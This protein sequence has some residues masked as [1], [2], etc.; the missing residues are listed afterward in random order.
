MSSFE[1]K[2]IAI[3][4]GTS[5][6]GLAIA[7]TLHQRGAKVSI[8]DA[9]SAA[10]ENVAQAIGT[11]DIVAVQC[12][13]RQMKEVETWLQRTVDRWGKLDGAANMAGIFSPMP[14]KGSMEE[15]TEEEWDMTIAVN[16]T[17]AVI[18][19]NRASATGFGPRGIRIN[20]IAPGY[21]DTPM[22]RAAVAG[23]EDRI[24][25]FIASLPI[26]RVADAEEAAEVVC[27][28]L[29]DESSYVTGSVYDVDGGY[30]L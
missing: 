26:G 22:Q 17:H 5:G 11:D 18:G 13:V 19:L 14:G 7:E 6:I 10:L 20:C 15:A 23:K 21:I 8:A 4:G 16:L 24:G 30:Q 3:T 27:F 28:L 9:N 29:S 2:V 25:T 12:D 1:R